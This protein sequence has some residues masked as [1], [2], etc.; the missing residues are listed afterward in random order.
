MRILLILVSLFTVAASIADDHAGGPFGEGA[1]TT[2]MIQA[3]D[4][5]KYIAAL[6]SNTQIME[7]NGAIAGGYCETKSGH[8]YPGQ[9]MVWTGYN[10]I[11]DAFVA[12]E[13]YDPMAK[14]DRAFAK[15]REVKYAVTWKPLKPFKLDPGYERVM[16]VVVPPSSLMEFVSHMSSTE[17]ALQAAGH[18]MNAGVFQPIGGGSAEANTVMVRFI[19]Q[20]PEAFGKVLDDY[21]GGNDYG[22]HWEK[23]MALTTSIVTDNMEA[24]A[25]TYARD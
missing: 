15:I 19:A 21:Y 11:S 6:E 20:N 10:S 14:P 17:K 24:C 5:E 4:T 16:R 7:N 23:G 2:I 12:S 13:L 8:A 22:G 1:F 18:D 3:N 25:Q 9:M